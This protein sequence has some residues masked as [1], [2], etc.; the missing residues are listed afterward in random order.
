M[1]MAVSTTTLSICILI[2]IATVIYHY[3]TKGIPSRLRAGEAPQSA[4]GLVRADK[5]SSD[6]HARAHGVEHVHSQRLLWT[7]C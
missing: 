7:L 6:E 3:L 1:G 2:A 4:F 5:F